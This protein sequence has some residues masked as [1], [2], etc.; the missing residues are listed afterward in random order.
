LQDEINQEDINQIYKK[1]HIFFDAKKNKK[2]KTIQISFVKEKK[3]K[4]SFWNIIHIQIDIYGNYFI[5]CLL[6]L[7]TKEVETNFI[8]LLGY[9]ILMILLLTKV[10]SYIILVI[11]K[12]KFF[13]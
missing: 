2:V 1:E 4:F 7:F 9:Y 8:I 5:I 6:L 11:K 10:I 3:P 12:Y 13:L